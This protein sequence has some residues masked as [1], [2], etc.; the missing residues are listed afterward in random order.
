MHVGVERHASWLDYESCSC[1]DGANQMFR[2]CTLRSPDVGMLVWVFHRLDMRNT[3]GRG[4]NMYTNS[5]SKFAVAQQ[6]FGVKVSC[7][8]PS[9]LLCLIFVYLLG[10]FFCHFV[11]AWAYQTVMGGGELSVK[12]VERVLKKTLCQSGTGSRCLFF[13]ISSQRVYKWSSV[14]SAVGS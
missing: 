9:K 3:S 13:F 14:T 12:Q 2:A 10:V 1:P 5:K 8:W 11:W 6:W 4:K 7:L